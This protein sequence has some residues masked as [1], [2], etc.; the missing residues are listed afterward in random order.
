MDN[1]NTLRPA[2]EFTLAPLA[3]LLPTP[4][5]DRTTTAEVASDFSLP[6]YLP[7]IKRL[8]RVTA[9]VLPESRYLGA[10][11]GE[12]SGAVEYLV[13]YSGGDGGLWSTRRG[14][15]I[16][17]RFLSTPNSLRTALIHRQT[18]RLIRWSAV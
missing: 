2:A 10:S 9:T 3:V 12:F 17:R 18:R 7:E 15:I 6:D 11:S 4:L 13:C 1:N 5:L 16:P 8:L 14:K